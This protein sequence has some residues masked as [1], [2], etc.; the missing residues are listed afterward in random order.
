MTVIIVPIGPLGE[1]EA[2]RES[3]SPLRHLQAV[4]DGVDLVQAPKSS[5]ALRLTLNAPLAFV[6]A[7]ASRTTIFVALRPR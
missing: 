4:D 6:R 1:I 5:G 7:V 3:R 2:E